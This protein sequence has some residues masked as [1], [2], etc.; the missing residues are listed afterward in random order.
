[1]NKSAEVRLMYA[2]KHASI[3]NL[4]KNKKGES[5]GLKKLNVYAKK[6]ATE[7][8][9][10]AWIKEDPKRVAM[11]GN[12]INDFKEVY[13]KYSDLQLNSKLWYLQLTVYGS[14]FTQYIMKN[15]GLLNT[16]KEDLDDEALE[17]AMAKY[18]AM[19]DEHFAKY[20][21]ETEKNILAG[22]LKA[23]YNNVP[24]SGHPDFFKTIIKDYHN[25]IDLYVNAIF[26]KS[27]F[28][29]QENFN[30]FLKKPKAKYVER[31]LGYKVAA[32]I[33]SNIMQLRMNMTPLE[34][35]LA[36][37]KRLFVRALR[38]M[39]SDVVYYPN[40]NFTMRLTY[41]SILGTYR[42]CL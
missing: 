31:D 21:P 5:R 13:G 12:V 29:T 26:E 20:D 32:S 25:N 19:A 11:Y 16:L 8:K 30:K 34:K 23:Y 41:G 10:A 28:A 15:Q 17:T 33:Q 36:T 38:E 7:D 6:K 35:K 39:N 9:L 42:Y 14:K 40:A 22:A 37:T 18:K 24:A 1:M 3:S 27:I 2:S 4:W